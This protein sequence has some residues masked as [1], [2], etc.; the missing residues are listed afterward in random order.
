MIYIRLNYCELI[1][2]LSNPIKFYNYMVIHIKNNSKN[3]N[4]TLTIIKS[5]FY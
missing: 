2:R 3:I 4:Y 5:D 1:S